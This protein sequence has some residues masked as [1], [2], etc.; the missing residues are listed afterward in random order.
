MTQVSGTALKGEIRRQ[1][2]SPVGDLFDPMERAKTQ[3]LTTAN[4]RLVA[5]GNPANFGQPGVKSNVCL[6]IKLS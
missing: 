5:H 1:N 4:P 6:L 3:I 2:R